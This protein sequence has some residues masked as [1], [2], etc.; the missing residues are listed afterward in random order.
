MGH[1]LLLLHARRTLRAAKCH[2]RAVWLVFFFLFSGGGVEIRGSVIQV[3][4]YLERTVPVPMTM[5]MMSGPKA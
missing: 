4:M 3:C 1:L 2:E 5:T